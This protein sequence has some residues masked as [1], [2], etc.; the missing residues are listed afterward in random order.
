MK[1]WKEEESWQPASCWS[2][3]DLKWCFS[4]FA[5]VLSLK[6]KIK[7]RRRLTFLHCQLKQ[8]F[9]RT[10]LCILRTC[11][12]KL[13]SFLRNAALNILKCWSK[14]TLFIDNTQGQGG[15]CL[16]CGIWCSR[17]LPRRQ[18][19]IFD[20][21]LWSKCYCHWHGLMQSVYTVYPAV[22]YISIW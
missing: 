1:G 3:I 15:A 6:K 13:P 8:A 10:N 20:R 21:Y 5:E 16:Y 7:Q 12:G 22:T 14:A 19:W 9:L 2:C 18:P 17:V 4:V 11:F